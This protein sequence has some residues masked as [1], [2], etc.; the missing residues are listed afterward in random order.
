MRILVTSPHPSKKGGNI[1]NKE[2]GSP[3]KKKV[4]I[5]IF[6]KDFF[7]RNEQFWSQNSEFLPKLEKL[8]KY[9]PGSNEKIKK[10]ERA[11]GLGG[12]GWDYNARVI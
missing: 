4:K 3:L 6:I 10:Q 5:W 12:G 9:P 11:R 8:I 2:L 1:C 7:G